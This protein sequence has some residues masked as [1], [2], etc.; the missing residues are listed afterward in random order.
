MQF[1]AAAAEGQSWGYQAFPSKCDASFNKIVL[2]DT[3]IQPAAQV[4]A[5]LP[6]DTEPHVQTPTFSASMIVDDYSCSGSRTVY[7]TSIATLAANLGQVLCEGMNMTDDCNIGH[8]RKPLSGCL[9]GSEPIVDPVAPRPSIAV[10]QDHS[11]T[12]KDNSA[13]AAA[14]IL[15]VCKCY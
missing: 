11:T 12:K 10:V 1:S 15:I 9:A 13:S 3:F 14:I 2:S 8:L 4:H 7:A 5:S 6:V